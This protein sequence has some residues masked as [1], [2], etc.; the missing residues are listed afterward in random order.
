M[1]PLAMILIPLNLI[2]IGLYMRARLRGDL[3]KVIVYQPGA[4]ILSLSIAD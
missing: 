1:T 3:G 4:V 2:A